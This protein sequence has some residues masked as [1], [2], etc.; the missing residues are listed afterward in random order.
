MKFNA[1]FALAP[2]ILAAAILAS[3][4]GSSPLHAQHMNAADAPCRGAG[5]GV[6]HANCLNLAARKADADLNLVYRR[7]T[8]ILEAPDRQKLQTAER[9]WLL[10][11]DQTCAAERD[12]YQGG[13]GGLTAYP[14]CLEAVTRQRISDLKTAY[15]WKVEKF[16]GR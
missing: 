11:R 7:I 3:F 10:Y 1:L 6:E 13:T 12:L 4:G 9:T 16:G 14:A 8:G 2:S 5:S 15:W